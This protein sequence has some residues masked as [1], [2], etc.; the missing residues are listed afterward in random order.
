MENGAEI[1]QKTDLR[2]MKTYTALI[3]A[4]KALLEEKRF[5]D[6]TVNEL[7]ERAMTRR[8]TFYKHFADKYE[9]FVFMAQEMYHGYSREV[10][11]KTNP[12]NP[13]E[14]YIGLIQAVLNFMEEN[15]RLIYSLNSSNTLSV[16]M[17]TASQ[18]L[19]ADLEKHFQKDQQ[20]G[21]ILPVDL[22]LATQLFTGA[23]SK[24]VRWWFFNRNRMSKEEMLEKLSLLIRLTYDM[25]FRHDY[26][27]HL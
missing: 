10:E 13:S 16:L 1:R 8:A 17:D 6:I 20:A 24:S 21:Y 7:C 15:E 12:D 2:V 11:Q 19:N 23:L 25:A 14:Y 22:E 27:F 18:S 9:F 26:P 3:N 5:E 4:F